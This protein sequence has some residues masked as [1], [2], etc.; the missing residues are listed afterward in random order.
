MLGRKLPVDILDRVKKLAS[1]GIEMHAQVVLCP[2][3]ND[4]VHLERTVRDLSEHYPQVR[5]VAL[6]PVGLT[7]FRQNLP[8]LEPVTTAHAREYIS[9]ACKWG[10][11]FQKKLG[12]RF[13]YAADELFLLE[14]GTPP[15]A[16]YYDAFPQVE[17]GIG[18]MRQFLDTWEREK[19][20]LPVCID[21]EKS[22]GLVTGVLGRSFLEPIAD[23]LRQ[24]DGLEVDVLCVENDFFGRGITV[25]GLLA[26]EDIIKRIKTGSWDV[27]FL[28][29]NCINGEGLTLDD[30][31]VAD[32]GRAV[33]K[34]MAVGDYD[35]AA[36]LN[37]YL[38]KENVVTAGRG[39]QLSELG[40]YMG[41]FK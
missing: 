31:T 12:E 26:G 14:S 1:Y 17:N 16:D 25:S 19:L 22:L 4:G 28:P 20:Q 11:E 30:M 15:R 33:D 35:L 23:E 7:Q 5:S 32:L 34:P 8:Q 9:L 24:I 38:C 10:A 3:W 21:Q 18:M 13:V 39:R 37:N 36:S 2:G 41:R 40:Y 6:V 27:V 29:P